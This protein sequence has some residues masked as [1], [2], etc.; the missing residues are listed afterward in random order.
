M[1]CF[2]PLPCIAVRM[3]A[4]WLLASMPVVAVQAGAWLRNR[5]SSNPELARGGQPSPLIGGISLA[6]LV[7][8]VGITV[9]GP[10][11]LVWR[12]PQ[13]GVIEDDLAEMAE[14][15][16]QVPGQPRHLFCRFEWG[17]Y[18]SWALRPDDYLI[19]ADGRIEIYPDKVWSDYLAVADGRADWQEILDRYQVNSLVLNTKPTGHAGA[20]RPLVEHSKKW[21]QVCEH[22][23][24]VLFLRVPAAKPGPSK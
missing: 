13:E 7:M 21:R 22:G 24:A 19:F 16:R 20:L 6:V 9:P 8:F 12:L 15:L 17:E 18:L 3:I 4:W 14:Q 11:R 5:F 1:L 2:L 23:E 10:D